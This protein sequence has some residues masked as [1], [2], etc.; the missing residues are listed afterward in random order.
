MAY[1]K[2]PDELGTITVNEYNGD[3][4]WAGKIFEVPEGIPVTF[5]PDSYTPKSGKNAGKKVN[6]F[7]IMLY[8]PPETTEEKPPF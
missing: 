6:C 1:E 4:Y 7:R 5:V 3:L 8:T 2:N